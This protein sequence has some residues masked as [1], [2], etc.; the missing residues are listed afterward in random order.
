MVS[1]DGAAA[2]GHAAVRQGAAGESLAWDDNVGVG[3]RA[4]KAL[5]GSPG[6]CTAASS[7]AAAWADAFNHIVW[8]LNHCTTRCGS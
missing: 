1:Q 5:A 7:R 4:A 3:D 2:A 6:V 8:F